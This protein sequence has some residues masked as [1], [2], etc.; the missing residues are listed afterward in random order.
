MP[1][2]LYDENGN[3]VE[4]FDTEEVDALKKEHDDAVAEKEAELAALKEAAEKAENKGENFKALRDKAKGAE[5]ALKVITTEFDK[6]L[7]AVRTELTAD[8]IKEN[9]AYKTE[10]IEQLSQGDKEIA[11]KMELEFK[12]FNQTPKTKEEIKA[13]AVKSYKLSVEEVKPDFLAGIVGSHG[14]S[15]NV[16]EKKASDF[17]PNA[18]E[19]AKVFGITK[20]VEELNK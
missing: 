16:G 12:G 15:P 5:E 17:S 7:D 14:K 11:K 6:K 4:A 18:L 8:K 9:E 19:M 13:L 10:I 20:E 2:T 3:E 1:K